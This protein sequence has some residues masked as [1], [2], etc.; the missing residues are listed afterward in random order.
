M[1]E[2]IEEE[3]EAQAKDSDE[4]RN[5]LDLAKTPEFIFLLATCL[6]VLLLAVFKAIP[7]SK[8]IPLPT[9]QV[10]NKMFEY[11]VYGI[12]SVLFVAI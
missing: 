12:F 7:S 6:F 4:K 2:L 3:I 11:W 10:G 1:D 5:A 8:Y 9:L